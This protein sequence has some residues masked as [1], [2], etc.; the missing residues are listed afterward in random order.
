[1]DGGGLAA[2]ITMLQQRYPRFRVVVVE[3][4]TA[5]MDFADLRE[6]RVDVMFGRSARANPPADIEQI[7]L[8]DEAL[9]VVTGG[10]N[11]WAHAKT[12]CYA[13]LA[14][15]PWVLAPAGTAV[16]ELVADAH[17]AEGVEMAAA[18]ITTYSM[19]LRLQLLASGQFV[20]AFPESLVRNCAQA[21]NLAAPRAAA[22]RRSLTLR[23]RS[24]GAA[25]E[26]RC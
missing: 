20:T 7:K 16:Y 17:R 15:R 3:S 22:S 12:M 18:A 19:M 10:H 8:L 26:A 14:G 5:A 1:M 25:D 21:W 4:N 2:T 6:R 23:V 13:D 24:I 9:E 11:P